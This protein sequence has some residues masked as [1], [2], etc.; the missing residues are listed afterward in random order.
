MGR[1]QV[2]IRLGTTGRGD[3]ERDFA[4]I[5]DSGEAQAKRYQSAWERASAEAERALDRQAKAAARMQSANVSPVQ[6][7]INATTGVGSVQSGNA[8]AAAAALASQLEKAEQEARQL[9]AAIDP[10][11]A[12]QARY[13]S[14]I[15]RINAVRATGQLTE[16]RYQQLIANEKVVLDQATA[17][18][19][20]NAN[21]RGTMRMGMQQLGFQMNDIATQMALGT[22]ASV[23]FAQQS[24]QVVQSFQLMGGQG[25]AFLKFLG[26]PW[27]IALSV[28]VVALSPLV[29]RLFETSNAVDILV[30]KLKKEA[31]Q[32]ADNDTAHR[33]FANTLEGVGEALRKNRELLDQATEAGKSQARR[34]LEAA[35]AEAERA[36]AIRAT[37]VALLEQAQA[38]LQVVRAQASTSGSMRDSGASAEQ[39]FVEQRISD[40][41]VQL[42]NAQGKLSEAETQVAEATRQRLVEIF[43][44][45]AVTK[46]KHQ[47]DDP[48]TGLIALA[49]RQ[50]TAEELV[51]GVLKRRVELLGRERDAKIKAE[52][53]K[54]RKGPANAGGTAI[55]DSQIAAY[56]DTAAKYRG[57]SETRN[58]G[59]L[60][61]FFREA[62]QNL[63]PEK[64]KWCAAFVNAVL[65]ANG[66]KGTGSLAAASFLNFGKDDTRSPQRG[67]IAV[68]R[69]SAGEHTGFVE[70]VDKAGNVRMLAGNTSD[71]V[72]SATYSKSQVL[73]IRRPPTP[74]ESADAADKAATA[75]ARAADEAL[76][77]QGTFDGERERLNQQM[78][79]ELR[80]VAVGYEAQAAIALRDA[81]ADHDAEAQKIATN[82]AQGDYGEK[83]SQLA[84]TRAEQ[85]RLAN[86]DLLKQRQAAINAEKARRDGEALDAATAREAQFKLD[87]LDYAESIARTAGERRKLQ[88]EIIDV[89]YQEKERHLQ[90]LLALD[91]LLGNTEDAAKVA[92]ELAHLPEQKA[93]AQDQANRSNQTPFEAYRDSLPK[94]MAEVG[95]AMQTSVVSGLKSLNEGLDDALMKSKNF[96]ELWHN[97]GAVVHDVFAQILKDLIDL[98][99]KMFIIKPLMDMISGGTGFGGVKFATGTE[100]A[101]GG[102]AWVGEHGP[103]MVQLPR[104]SKVFTA[105]TSRRMAANDSGPMI[106]S[107]TLNNDFRGADPS[108][109]SSINARLDQLERDFPGL[110]VNAYQDAVGRFVIRK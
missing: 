70:S 41:T 83:T 17:A 92:A 67:D 71:R 35:L 89:E 74:S 16:A 34:A 4:A 68:V 69:T 104:G 57:M 55:F 110:V 3:V 7:Q 38:Q 48:R 76:R 80:K 32:S 82:L 59:V 60:E 108:A 90:Y 77:A 56:F 40:I 6:Q 52:Q 46:I 30:E 61:A 20:R 22:R 85:L 25:N 78:L 45:D 63:D 27:G 36:R 107:L 31:Q 33:I 86:D 88:L 73:A 8:K 75:A 18:S 11:F 13:E 105:A 65:A 98:T 29:S 94:D 87:G 79:A 95:E 26:G 99:I 5:G 2:S 72:G 14:Q 23:I 66:A 84:L 1:P 10:L 81:Q 37:N 47:Y 101:P 24:A 54:D 53:E 106:G 102:A 50:A 91:K 28:A 21:A 93:R 62:G 96:K 97:M 64:V 49:G 51:N 58:K 9:I 15:E 43:S 19:L 12:A 109:V 44:E 39:S 100:Y 42:R 103:E